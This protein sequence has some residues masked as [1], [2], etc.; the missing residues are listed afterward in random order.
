MWNK[1]TTLQKCSIV[2]NWFSTEPF[3][4]SFQERVRIIQ[5]RYRLEFGNPVPCK[6]TIYTL[7]YKHRQFGSVESRWKGNS[8]RRRSVRTPETISQVEALVIADRDLPI[9]RTVNT[10]LSNTLNL[11]AS[12][13][14][15]ILKDDLRL[16]CF[17][18][19]KYSPSTS[20]FC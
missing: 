15:R 8:G 14:A 4:I 6:S 19:V 2:Q 7:V 5:H 12:T 3:N 18:W 9:D 1:Y 16:K 13:W 17:R 11:S 10:A 20:V